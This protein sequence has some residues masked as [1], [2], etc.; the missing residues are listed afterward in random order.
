MAVV[1]KYVCH[2][3]LE[4]GVV[5]PGTL[6]LTAE[7]ASITAELAESTNESTAERARSTAERIEVNSTTHD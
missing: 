5:L 1:G 3:E 4:R 6:V 2:I 7:R